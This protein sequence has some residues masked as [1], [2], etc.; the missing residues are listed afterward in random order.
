MFKTRT[1]LLAATLFLGLIGSTPGLAQDNSPSVAFNLF[2]VEGLVVGDTYSIN[3][4]FGENNGVDVPAPFRFMTPRQDG[5]QVVL[6]PPQEGSGELIK[7]NFT[8]EDRQLIENM[9]FVK[10]T[11]PM[12]DREERL[13][14]MASV[15]ANDGYKMAVSSYSEHEFIG[16]RETKIG[17]Y[18]GV[19]A[20]GKYIDADLGLMYVRLI[21]VPNP[22][23]PDSVVAV[24][25]IVA[26]RVPLESLD[27][28]ARTFTGTALRHFE[29]L[30]E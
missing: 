9:R 17:D 2:S 8:T 6:E 29:Y 23:G 5:M 22:D 20:I 15:L 19:E 14:S 28:L 24:A 12:G 3:T 30:D 7:V 10:M 13:Q 26:S 4:E 18:D 16:V 21:G 27:D 25:N 1:G 11:L